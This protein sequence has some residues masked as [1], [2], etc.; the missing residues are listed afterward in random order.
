MSEEEPLNV[1]REQILGLTYKCPKGAY[2][3]DC[4]FGILRGLS[5]ESRRSTLAQ[6]DRENLL[7][8]FD[9]PLTCACL[10]D[11]RAKPSA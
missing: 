10:A 2:T 1:L 4:P 11:P 8:L 9:L 5:H 3:G 6:M 7:N